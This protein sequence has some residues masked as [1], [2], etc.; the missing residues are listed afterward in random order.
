[1]SGLAHSSQQTLTMHQVRLLRLLLCVLSCASVLCLVPVLLTILMFKEKR[2]TLGGSLTAIF[3]LSVL[4]LQ[5]VR[6]MPLFWGFDRMLSSPGLCLAQAVGTQFTSLLGVLTFGLISRNLYLLIASRTRAPTTQLKFQIAGA[7]GV[8]ALLT[9]LPWGFGAFGRA[10][11]LFCWY[12][13]SASWL[14]QLTTFSCVMLVVMC[15][16]AVY[17]FASIGHIRQASAQADAFLS[18]RNQYLSPS[19]PAYSSLA[20]TASL[21]TTSLGGVVRPSSLSSNATSSA[22]SLYASAPLLGVQAR[23]RPDYKRH[24]SFVAIFMLVCGIVAVNNVIY[25]V[26]SAVRART[27]RGVVYWGVDTV[28]ISGIGVWIS[29]TIGFSRANLG[30]WQRACCPRSALALGEPSGIA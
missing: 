14:W 15:A 10:G 20:A 29:L 3:C 25:A 9:G 23:A 21:P 7:S 13:D 24:V 17:W 30:L 2:K 4:A 8:A 28:V 16:S 11:V 22:V 26:E 6:L 27:S 19:M 1:M 5:L 12:A 18:V